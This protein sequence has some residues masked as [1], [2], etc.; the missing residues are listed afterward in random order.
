M[1][2]LLP[3]IIAWE[4]CEVSKDTADTAL[5]EECEFVTA[6]CPEDGGRSYWSTCE[7][8]GWEEVEQCFGAACQP[9]E[10]GEIRMQG[11]DGESWSDVWAVCADGYGHIEGIICCYQ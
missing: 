9:A 10:H 5:P 8:G 6:A 3:I 1:K 2:I 4:A 7:G 11:V